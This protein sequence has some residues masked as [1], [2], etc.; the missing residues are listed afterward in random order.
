LLVMG[1][2]AA[3]A[4]AD[5]PELGPVVEAWERQYT[6]VRVRPMADEA[7]RLERKPEIPR[8]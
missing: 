5:V 4:R 8:V 3:N 1:G 2:D 6:L 7:H